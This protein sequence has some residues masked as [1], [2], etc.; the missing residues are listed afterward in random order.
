MADKLREYDAVKQGDLNKL[1][2]EIEMLRCKND[3]LIRANKKYEKEEKDWIKMKVEKNLAIEDLKKRNEDKKSAIEDL[4]R[5]HDVEMK[6]MLNFKKNENI[7]KDYERVKT[8]LGKFETKYIDASNEIKRLVRF[9]DIYGKFEDFKH[10]PVTVR[11]TLA[12]KNKFR[13]AVSK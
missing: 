11:E 13:V 5:R 10:R 3:R 2:E 6:A 7:E 8:D 1:K 12:H 9:V 4:K